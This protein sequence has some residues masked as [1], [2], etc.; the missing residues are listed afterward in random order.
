MLR[1]GSKLGKYRIDGRLADGGFARVYRAFDTIEGTRVAL[2]I[3]PEGVVA[4]DSKRGF[5]A[6]VRIAAKLEHPNILPIKDAS[7]I[8]GRFVIVMPLGEGTL[9]D[10]LTKRIATA[11]ALEYTK[12][13]LSALAYAHE[14]R[15]MH[16]DVKPDNL[17]LFDHGTRLRLADFGIARFAMHSVKGSGSGTLGYIA[18]EQAMGKPSLRSDVFSIALIVYRM[19]TGHLPEWPYAWP[20]PGHDKARRLLHPDFVEWLRR[21]LA[22]E[23]KQRFESAV[24]MLRSFQRF[25]KHALRVTTKSAKTKGRE[26]TKSRV[27]WR[28]V[29][30]QAFEK[31]FGRLLETRHDC[32]ECEGPIAESMLA[33]PWCSLRL[34]TFPYPDESRF[35]LVCPRCARG[36]KL[37]W[38]FCAWCHGYGF[39]ASERAYADQRYVAKKVAK[40]NNPDCDRKSLMPFMRYCPWC[41]KKVERKWKL[42]GHER[43]TCHHCGHGVARDYWECC[44][45]CR[46]KLH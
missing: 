14:R 10:R 35:P 27:D 12:Q 8:E 26:R 36:V 15:V 40:C 38:R 46:T 2:K 41:R 16:C 25:E 22:V 44:P 24:S 23:P 37:D 3:A 5:G 9:D 4:D 33:C 20:S 30:F 11:R 28:R 18:P 31:T 34:D 39:E 1:S 19:F 13:L 32:P 21:G 29:R 42:L 7:M 43:E 6:E 17:I 45:W